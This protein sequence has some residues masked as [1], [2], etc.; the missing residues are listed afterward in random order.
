VAAAACSKRAITGRSALRPV[1]SWYRDAA[2]ST[3]MAV[4]EP[5][6]T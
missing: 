1:A 4:S 6:L 3:V 5:Y 2:A